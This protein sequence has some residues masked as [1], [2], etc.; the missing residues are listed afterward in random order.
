MRRDNFIALACLVIIFG[1]FAV[2]RYNL[3][4]HELSLHAISTAI[5]A[6]HRPRVVYFFASW[7]GACK[8]YGPRLKKC[9]AVYGNTFDFQTINVEDPFS[10]K[11]YDQLRTHSVPATCIFNTRGEL[12]LAETGVLDELSINDLLRSIYLETINKPT[13]A[14]A[15]KAKESGHRTKGH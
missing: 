5:A 2:S 1:A 6:S 7:C 11:L 12:V 9:V 3:S 15:D 8:I 13:S 10:R 4:P 14:T